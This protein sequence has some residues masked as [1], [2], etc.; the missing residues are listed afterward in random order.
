MKENVMTTE[1]L[2]E[3]GYDEATHN[4]NTPMSR[5]RLMKLKQKLLDAIRAAENTLPQPGIV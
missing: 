3:H 1:M 2:K 4:R 5:W